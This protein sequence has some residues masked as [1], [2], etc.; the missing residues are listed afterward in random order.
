MRMNARSSVVFHPGEAN[1]LPLP[2]GRFLPPLPEGSV[3]SWLREFHEPPGWV[4]DPLNATPALALEAA[5]AGYRVVVASNNPVLSFLLE[6]LASAPRKED[7]LAALAALGAARRGEERLE[8]HLRALYQTT[9]ATCG[10]VTQAQAFLWRRGEPTPYARL[11]RCEHCQEQA[12]RPLAEDDLER[13]KRIGNINLHRARALS[14]VADP[15]DE[16]YD[17]VREALS[18]YLD[19]PLYVLSTLINRQEGL[20]LSPET[21]RWL[22]ALLISACDAAS[23]LWPHGVGRTR[24]RQLGMPAQFRENNLWLAMEEAIAVWSAQPGAVPLVHWPELPPPGGISLFTGRARGLIPLPEQ[25]NPLVILTTFPRPNQ[26]FWTLSAMWSGWLWGREAALPLRALLERKRF[27]W[28][29]YANAMVS[30]FIAL[31]KALPSGTPLIGLIPEATAGFLASIFTAAET[32]GWNLQGLA[33]REDE[34]MAQALWYTGQIPHRSSTGEPSQETAFSEGMRETLAGRAEPAPYLPVYAGGLCNLLQRGEVPTNL[35]AGELVTRIQALAGRVF[36]SRTFIF[37]FEGSSQEEERSLWWLTDPPADLE[38]PLADRVER[39]VI[40]SLQR[41][42]GISRRALEEHLCRLFP[43]LLTPPADLITAVLESYASELPGSPGH[44]QLLPQEAPARRRAD[45]EEVRHLL[46]E[47]GSRMGFTASGELPLVWTP[48]TFGQVYFFYPMASSL[49]SRF[50]L[51]NPPGPV[52]QCVMVFPGGRA[53]LLSFKLR[54][55]PRLANLL[56]GWHLLKFR[57]L[58]HLAERPDLTPEVWENLLDAD[59]PFFE[60]A[61]QMRLL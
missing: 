52:R 35:T 44:W 57:H 46:L 38:E 26:A 47:L 30:P 9:C 54:R 34:E 8:L 45:L 28:A 24:P 7:F 51:G 6:T 22:Q 55:D 16:H 15:E 42:P 60:E 39:E 37:R 27:D 19:R 12:E 13:L 49:V 32:S 21:R 11:Y 5:R 59:P 33:L 1:T 36:A 25:I 43:G 10:G 17:G 23:A 20:A 50:V 2:L 31:A 53:R 61:E 14:R 3:A 56:K 29:W 18:A 40:R 58:R 41:E 4:I 48:A